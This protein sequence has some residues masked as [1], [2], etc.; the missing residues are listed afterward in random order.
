MDIFD[1]RVIVGNFF[2]GSA[3]RACFRW[4][5][6]EGSVDL[7][8]MG[9]GDYCT[10]SAINSAGRIVGWANTEPGGVEH[11][12][13]Y[14]NGAFRDLGDGNGY[15]A[16]AVDVNRQ[17]HVVGGIFL[18]KNGE[19]IDLRAGTPYV[20]MIA[21]SINDRDEIVGEAE[22]IERNSHSVMI[23]GGHVTELETA[24]DALRDWQLTYA[25][26]INNL[27]EIVGWGFRTGD[28]HTHT[29]MLVPVP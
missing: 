16:I 27:G 8:L 26:F 4:S 18:W 10:A 2:I 7:G 25:L 12:F 29:F 9:N 21:E 19:T 22:D 24:V 28:Q 13:L 17:G 23:K 11:P 20:G 5:A 6:A 3:M 1:H 15:G 14:E